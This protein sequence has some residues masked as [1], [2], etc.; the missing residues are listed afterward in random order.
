MAPRVWEVVGGAKTG[1]IVVRKGQKLSSEEAAEKLAPQSLVAELA[2]EGE[3]LH[4]RLL[5][6]KGPGEGWVSLKLKGQDLLVERA[7]PLYP[8]FGGPADFGAKLLREEDWEAKHRRSWADALGEELE[9]FASP[10]KDDPEWKKALKREF[11]TEHQR[12]QEELGERLGT[13]RCV[14][15]S[16]AEL[17]AGGGLHLLCVALAETG[18]LTPLLRIARACCA[19]ESVGRVSFVS[20]A[21]GS[22]KVQKWLEADPEPTG[23][24]ALYAFEDGWTEELQGRCNFFAQ[25]E[26]GSLMGL[27]NSCIARHAAACLQSILKGP[28]PVS[29]VLQDFASYGYSGLLEV[30]KKQL[31]ARL[32]DVPVIVSAPATILGAFIFRGGGPTLVHCFSAPQLMPLLKVMEGLGNDPGELMHSAPA[33]AMAPDKLKELMSVGDVALP[34]NVRAVGIIADEASADKLPK[35]LVDFLEKPGPVV[36]VSMGSVAAFSAEELAKVLLG[37]RPPQK[38]DWRVLW[39]LRKQQQELLPKDALKG[40]EEDFLISAWL[41]QA[42]LLMH[43]K[44]S[45]FV[46]HCGWGAT[47][48]AIVSGTPVLAMPMFADQNANALLMNIL[49]MAKT[50]TLPPFTLDLLNPESVARQ[51]EPMMDVSRRLR[52]ALT[53]EG[54]RADV[55][56]VLTEK[57]Y[58]TGAKQAR[59][60]NKMFKGGA[61]KAAEEVEEACYLLNPHLKR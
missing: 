60:M 53:P 37:L 52:P 12:R 21:F 41:P 9:D 57:K 13:W 3:R 16:S 20:S 40:L 48:E 11:Q 44:V 47:C 55:R 7:K 28:W 4:F 56:A 1:G 6:G 49:G 42:E 27:A 22:G 50:A 23:K 19:R 15:G 31:G 26:D 30:A 34:P 39:S 51:L 5:H 36:Y 32:A 17:G 2:L 10:H 18:H 14:I 45:A 25:E 58:A 29:A 8:T 33:N 54:L 35:D 24:L 61:G 38:G 46:S 59:T 43:K